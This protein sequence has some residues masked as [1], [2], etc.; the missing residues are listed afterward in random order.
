MII[1]DEQV[2]YSPPHESLS[3]EG[4]CPLTQ[5]IHSHALSAHSLQF[6]IV[7]HAEE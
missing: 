5:V 2:C 7:E 6:F 4:T 3:S 1:S